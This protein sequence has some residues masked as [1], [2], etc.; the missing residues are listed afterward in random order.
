MIICNKHD[1]QTI[2]ATCIN[3]LCLK[4][5]TYTCIYV[6]ITKFN[7]NM[8]QTRHSM[9]NCY[10][11][12]CLCCSVLLCV[13]VCCSVLLS[14]AVCCSDDYYKHDIC[15]DYHKHNNQKIIVTHITGLYI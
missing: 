3:G 12:D 13:A 8:L 6:I 15:D 2:I 4:K 9:H 5:R 14:V 10:I 11:Y 1:I 7:E